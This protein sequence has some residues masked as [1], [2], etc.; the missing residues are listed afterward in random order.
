MIRFDYYGHACFVLDNGKDRL[1]FDPFLT[2]NPQ[3]T[4]AAKDVECNY[5]LL[6]HAHG[7]HFGDAVEIA[8]RT[9]AKVIAIPEILG[10]F[11][12]YEN[13][14]G[15]NLGGSFAFPFGIVTMVP[16]LHSSG[17]AGGV[18]CGFFIRF[19]NEDDDDLTVYYSGDTALFS[20]MKLIGERRKIDYA[21][22]PIG[23][24]YTMGVN[25]AAKAVQLLKPHYAIPIHCGTWP[26]IKQYP[27][28]FKSHAESISHSLVVLVKPGESLDMLK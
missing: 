19:I 24:N 13:V 27:S 23:D 9:N 14:H 21:I 26:V 4:I 20:D 25:D 18:A 22:L 6:T 2:D 16:A 7:D 8:K 15:M 3:A 17:V 1:L 5:I 12:N 28:M 11:G 10:L